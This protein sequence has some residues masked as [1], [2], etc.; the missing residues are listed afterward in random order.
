MTLTESNRSRGA[1]WGP[2]DQIVF[3]A[4]PGEGLSVIPA[5]GGAATVLTT[6][7]EEAGE[8]SLYIREMLVQLYQEVR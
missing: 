7:D 6:L 2:D 3:A 5:T 4:S 8:L 1:S